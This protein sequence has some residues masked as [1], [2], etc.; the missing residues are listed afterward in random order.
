ML[1]EHLSQAHDAA[2]RRSEIIDRHV[3]WIHAEILSQ[4]PGR[5]LDLGCGPG[6]Y[7]HR[8]ATLGH[9]CTGIDFSP[10]SVAYAKEEARRGLLA[11]HY[12]HDDIRA[13]KFP[14]GQDLVMLVSG[15]LNVFSPADAGRILSK[16]ATCLRRSGRLLLEVHAPG[17]IPARGR[18]PPTWSTSKSGLW[19][20][21][22]HVC[23]QE[24]FWDAHRQTA[25]T[26]YFIIDAATGGVTSSAAS[27][28]DYSDAEYDSVLAE[29]GFT[30]V[31]R[32]PSL[33]GMADDQQNSFAVLLARRA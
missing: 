15:E 29:S 27:Y 18:Q 5:I 10:A 25:T 33:T 31:R 2:S 17:V 16:A 23:L 20:D 12:E 1:E 19:S 9:Q 6:L 24:N 13:A 14:D 11:I 7:A 28:Q 32:Y 8:L 30:H 22:P 3:G 21:S 4:T 26:R